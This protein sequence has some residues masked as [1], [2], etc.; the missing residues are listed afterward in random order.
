MSVLNKITHN[1]F[2]GEVSY[3][4]GVT[5]VWPCAVN[6]VWTTK[7]II[8]FIHLYEITYEYVQGKSWHEGV[9][10]AMS[11][12]QPTVGQWMNRNAAPGHLMTMT[13]FVKLDTDVKE[14]WYEPLGWSHVV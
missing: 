6:D 12:I 4:K 8:L 7:I 3:I 5:L 1:R 13:L 2:K 9:K 14:M 10:V 11:S